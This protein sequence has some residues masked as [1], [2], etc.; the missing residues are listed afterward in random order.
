MSQ[1]FSSILVSQ[2]FSSILAGKFSSPGNV[3]PQSQSPIFMDIPYI[4][5]ETLKTRPLS[6]KRFVFESVMDV[7][8]VPHMVLKV[9]NIRYLSTTKP[10]SMLFM[11]SFLVLHMLLGALQI[12]LRATQ[13][14][15]AL[16]WHDHW[17][18]ATGLS[19]PG[20]GNFCY[21]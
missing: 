1:A 4:L 2:A 7:F 10:V 14:C 6:I 16:D 9:P 21:T 3:D 20:L 18:S 12:R 19:K 17:R 8:S 15:F 11:I 13:S 5:L